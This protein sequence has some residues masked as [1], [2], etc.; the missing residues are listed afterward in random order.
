MIRG[1]AFTRTNSAV[2]AVT[3]RELERMEDGW[4]GRGRR[5]G[6]EGTREGEREGE[7]ENERRM[8]ATGKEIEAG[9]LQ[10]EQRECIC[11]RAEKGE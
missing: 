8:K 10:R 1:A 6:I 4:Y 11:A 9:L 7:I 5:K 3:R 2:H